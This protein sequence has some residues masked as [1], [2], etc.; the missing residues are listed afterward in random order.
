M[1]SPPLQGI[2]VLDLTHEWSGPHCT[3]ILADFGAEVIRVEHLR[4]L[5][6][7]RGGRK[8]DENYNRQPPWYQMNRNKY[9][10][11]LDLKSDTGRDILQDLVECSDVLVENGRTGVMDRLGFPYER[12]AELNPA[13]VMVSMS[14][15]G[16]SGP[17]AP[18]PAYGAALEV[19]SGIQNLTAYGEGQKPH[20]FREMD[21][22]N[23]VGGACGVM[24]GLLY[25]QRTG[26][27]QH[28]DLAQL[29]LPSHAFMGEHML[30]FVMNGQHMAPVGNRSRHFAPQGCYRCEGEDCWV[31]L[32]VRSDR[33]WRAL[34][35][36]IEQP[37]LADDS[38]FATA[39]DRRGNHDELDR[40]IEAWTSGRTRGEAMEALQGSGVP[41][42][43][44]LD[45][46]GLAEDPQLHARGYF[47]NG[48]AGTDKPLGGLPF[49][50]SEGA[51]EIRR[52]GPDLGEH[53][54][55]VIC[56]LLGRPEEQV[57]PVQP[58]AI[59]TAYDPD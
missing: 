30:E 7:F 28:V 16:N 1:Q 31:T 10:V 50:L 59:G 2:R 14:A 58:D 34:C 13:M 20:R 52:R 38:R 47:V 12:I 37:G 45:P 36:A 41:A 48:V 49:K 25:R 27:G 55:H 3:R 6:M 18:Y 43:A 22:I 40:L 51:G 4:R 56:E 39:E 21:V 5:C 29:E 24:T 17:Y 15:Y 9:S 42:G 11:T 19:M 54:A 53:N 35:E 23:G 46:A 44:V 33:E 57:E 8:D 32:T 26:R